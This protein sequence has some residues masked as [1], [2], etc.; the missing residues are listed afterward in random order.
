MA[1][2][3]A[4]LEAEVMCIAIAHEVTYTDICQTHHNDDDDTHSDSSPVS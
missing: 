4:Q 2:Q 1:D 3:T